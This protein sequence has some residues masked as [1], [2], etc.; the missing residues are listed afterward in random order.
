MMA[1]T[2][3]QAAKVDSIVATTMRGEHIAGLSLGIA[4]AGV[5]LYL[6]GYGERDVAR[7]LPADP[8]TVYYV[9]SLTKQF[10]AALVLQQVERGTFD[11][12]APIRRYVP[13]AGGTGGYTVAELLGQT[14]GLPS[15]TDRPQAELAQLA[16]SDPSPQALW[17]LV[18]GASP[19]FAPGSAWQYS[20]SNYLLLGIALQNATATEY[21]ALLRD[22]IAA[23]LR[24]SATAYG[25]AKHGQ[26]VAR[27]YAWN[28]VLSPMEMSRGTIDVAFSAGGMRSNVLDLLAWLEA[29]R[30][31]RVVS[32][33]YVTAMTASVRL[34][35]GIAAGYGFGFY[36]GNWYGYR[37]ADH[38]GDIDG[39]SCEDALVLDDGLELAVLSNAD[40]LDL[41]PLAKSLVAIVEPPRDAN[42]YA[43]LSQPAENE[44]PRVTA[45]VRAIASTPGFAALGPLASVE[46]TERRLEG[47]LVYDRYRLTFATGQWWM[48]FGY[49]DDAAIESLTFEPDRR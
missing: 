47:G 18:A 11:L 24:L 3:A 8:T 38:G 15:Y 28:G 9:G 1:L 12:D 34:N 5:P 37:V 6:K 4:R 45:A 23:P 2:P 14:S 46:F 21:A 35:D 22:R 30:A 13:E 43:G 39:F 41:R 32:A 36:A 25:L 27:G 44:N 29:L 48:T 19:L 40:R 10:T 16:Q 7:A 26:D 49:R 42:L 17:Q 20:N 33:P 31:G